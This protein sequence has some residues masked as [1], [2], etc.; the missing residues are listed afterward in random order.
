MT[1][2]KLRLTNLVADDG[3]RYVAREEKAPEQR[4]GRQFMI[5]FTEV[6]AN[7][8]AQLGGN[9]FRV[10]GRLPRYLSCK[11]FRPVRRETLAADLNLAGSVVSTALVR[12]CEAGYVERKGKG[13]T[14]Q[15]R[16]SVELAWQGSAPAYHRERRK[17]LEEAAQTKRAALHVVPP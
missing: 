17:R 10:L 7:A 3:R 13:P 11:E 12:L 8:A 6:L 16:L 9:E 2:A 15:W 14:T 4:Y 5:F 1:H